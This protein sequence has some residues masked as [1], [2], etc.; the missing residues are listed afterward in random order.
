LWVHFFDPHAPYEG[1]PSRPVA[2]RYDAEIA[3]VDR[4]IG[5][6]LDAFGPQLAE[7]LVVATADH[8]EA[9]GEHGEY[10]HSIFIYD[11]T[12][13]VPLV[14]SG[15]GIAARRIEDAVTLADLAPTVVRRLGFELRD[16]DGVDL[17]PA[18]TGA[19]L[20][21]RELYAES[22]AP[23]VEFGW[24]P[25]RS[26]R[27]G[28]W[29]YIAAPKPELYDVARDNGEQQ[30]LVGAQKETAASLD[31]RVRRYSG[32]T[33]ADAGDLGG[34]AANRLRALGYTAR[35][36]SPDRHSPITNSAAR[37]DPKDRRELAARIAQVT[38]GELAG[39]ALLAAL[40]GIVRDDPRNGQAHLRL[41]YARVQAGDCARAIPAFNAAIASGL[42]SADAYLG[43]AGC[44]GERRDL[45][46]AEQ[47]LNEAR[48]LEPQ[49]PVVTANIGILKAGKGDAAGAIEALQ[50]AL[51][52]DPNLH[53]ARF[54]LALTYARTGRR[55]EAAA[56]A[57]ELL[58]RL[59]AGA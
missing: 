3:T 25:L 21:A 43:L 48:R 29:K 47:A 30:N 57:R 54:N 46:R 13:H 42:A 14:M 58:S 50:A 34:D 31:A 38:A 59:P 44:L 26:V 51:A 33:L 10:A 8:G 32:D 15:P 40:E 35:A 27:S 23:L 37:P 9:F 4:E 7:T 24:A 53:E 6:L 5:R 55:A 20:A 28:S 11:T 41:G 39:A 2:D 19:A 12:L 36:N 45:A 56:A 49:N 18:L 52:A 1:D 16:V 22:F 17:S